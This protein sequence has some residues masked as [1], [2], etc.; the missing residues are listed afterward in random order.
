VVF[1][2][3][4]SVSCPRRRIGVLKAAR[5]ILQPARRPIIQLLSAIGIAFALPVL[6][7]GTIG[8]VDLARDP[9]SVRYLVCVLQLKGFN[10]AL[11]RFHAD[12]GRY[13]NSTEGLAILVKN[14]KTSGW[15]GPYL[16][17]IP[18]DPWGRPYIFRQSTDP[19]EILSY[20][21]D[22]VP[23]NKPLSSL[24]LTDTIRSP[25]EGRAR[26][27][28][29]GLWISSWFLLIGSIFVLYR[30]SRASKGEAPCR[31]ND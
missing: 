2:V 11:Q 25:Y 8:D 23:G 10:E 31:S 7:L 22:G 3:L 14:Q 13:P 19:P 17:K 18:R 30:V 27:V 12:Y 28:L 26:R 16:P 1:C 9:Q 6:L 4:C 29:F 21:A 20:G 5:I 24:N 15:K